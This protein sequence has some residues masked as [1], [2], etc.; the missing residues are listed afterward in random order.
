MNKEQTQASRDLDAYF[1]T[2]HYTEEAML[3][4]YEQEHGQHQAN[5]KIFAKKKADDDKFWTA[6]GIL[7]VFFAFVAAL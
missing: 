7:V 6:I 1:L 5:E 2:G 4:D 3:E